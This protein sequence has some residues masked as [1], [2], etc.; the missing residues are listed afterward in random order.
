MSDPT[1]H[2]LQ[3]QGQCMLSNGDGN[4]NYKYKDQY[5]DTNSFKFQEECVSKQA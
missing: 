1:Y 2:V 5:K 3:K 4:Y